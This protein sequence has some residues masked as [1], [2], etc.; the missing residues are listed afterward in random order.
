VVYEWSPLTIGAVEGSELKIVSH[1]TE[2]PAFFRDVRGSSHG[3]RVVCADGTEEIWFLC[4]LVHYTTPRH[5]YHLL[6]ILDGETLAVK[7]HSILFKFHD[8][9]IEYALGLVVEPR[10]LLISY[11]RM[12]RTSAVM[13]IPR[14][15]VEAELFPAKA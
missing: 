8:E 14:D 15:V 6:V 4:H 13:E 9:C 5:Y 12:D 2:V 3:Q 1:R 11:S 10:R 7:R